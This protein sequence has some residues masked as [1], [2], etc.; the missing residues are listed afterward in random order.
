MCVFVR[1]SK[2]LEAMP[3]NVAPGHKRRSHG[4]LPNLVVHNMVINVVRV[5]AVLLIIT[6]YKQTNKQ[7]RPPANCHLPSGALQ[8][9]RLLHRG[10]PKE[11]GIG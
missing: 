5:L 3:R 9:L 6:V 7:T 2:A 1:R 4:G 11:L 10:N 8:P